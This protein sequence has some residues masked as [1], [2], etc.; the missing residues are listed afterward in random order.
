[1]IRSEIRS[2]A[3]AKSRL[4]WYLHLHTNEVPRTDT[5]VQIGYVRVVDLDI[6]ASK[7]DNLRDQSGQY[8]GARRQNSSLQRGVR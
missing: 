4:L 6:G 1:V 3:E 2:S 8:F 7:L 5:L